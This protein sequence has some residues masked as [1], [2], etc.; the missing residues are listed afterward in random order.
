MATDHNSDEE[1]N[2]EALDL[3]DVTP[4]DDAIEDVEDSEL[5]EDQDDDDDDDTDFEEPASLEEVAESEEA[6]SDSD[7]VEAD[8]SSILQERISAEDDDATEKSPTNAKTEND[9]TLVSEKDDE[10]LCSSCF[11]L[12]SQ[13]AINAADSCPNCG[14][15][16]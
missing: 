15:D 2:D 12:V 8:L 6:E 4:E 5:F 13:K 7:E 9:E 11:T 3:E 14:A 10:V 1:E 16:I